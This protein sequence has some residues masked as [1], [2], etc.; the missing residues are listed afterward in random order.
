[1][2]TQPN[3]PSAGRTATSRANSLQSARDAAHYAGA[4]AQRVLAVIRESGLR[5]ATDWDVIAATSIQ[6]SSVC[7]R[8]N[9]LIDAGLI[10]EHPDSRQRSRASGPF[11]R[12]CTVWVSTEHA[13]AAVA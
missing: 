12:R 7:A 8:R 3:L 6:R 11:G 1:M 10:V 4:Q 9:S 2:Q 5:G 13:K